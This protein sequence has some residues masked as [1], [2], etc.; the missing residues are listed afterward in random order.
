MFADPAVI[1]YNAV[2]K[3]LPRTGS[4]V[5]KSTYALNDSGVLYN[6]E[7]GHSSKK[8]RTRV[9]SKLQRQAAVTDPLI[10]AQNLQ[11]GGTCTISID[12][13]TQMT[14]A[15]AVLLAKAIRDYFTDAFLL[16]L[17]NQET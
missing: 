15:D 14:A 16:K 9:Y 8:A 5:D 7:N 3:S 1:T 11:V 17:V 13:A 2:A 6:L 10:P 4:A 12:F